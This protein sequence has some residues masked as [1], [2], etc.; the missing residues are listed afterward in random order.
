VQD[1]WVRVLAGQHQQQRLE[2]SEERVQ[3][4]LFA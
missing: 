4:R 2:A 3:I 1:K